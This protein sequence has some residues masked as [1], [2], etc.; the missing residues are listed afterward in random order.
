MAYLER[1]LS[2]FSQ[3]PGLHWILVEDAAEPSPDVTRLLRQRQSGISHELL[4]IG[5]TRCW[6]NA[7]RDLGL[8]HIRDR[9]LQGIVYLADDDN[10]YEQQVFSELGQVKRVAVLPVG[11][12]GPFGIERPIVRAGRIV[13]WRAHWKSRRFPVDMAGFAFDAALL[14]SIEGPIWIFS[15]RGGESEF[16]ERLVRSAEELEVLCDAARRCLVW[17]DLSLGRNVATA[18]AAYRLRRCVTVLVEGVLRPLILGRRP[19]D[20]QG[21]L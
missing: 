12:L 14:R 2:V 6:G 19:A 13:G 20:R 4:A 8:R 5:P 9:S 17:H 18:L 3:V 21:Q 15:G 16:L 10:G 11:L 1:C 7:Q